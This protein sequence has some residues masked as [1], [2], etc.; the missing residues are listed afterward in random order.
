VRPKPVPSLY[1]SYTFAEHTNANVFLD[2]T[3]LVSQYSRICF[4]TVR[5][6]KKLRSFIVLFTITIA[7]IKNKKF[8]L[9]LTK[10][11]K[12]FSSF[13]SVVKLKIE[14]LTLS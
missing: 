12:A 2:K 10:R 8:K 1:F 5:K 4:H 14:V 6:E 7:T 9:M 13:G 3:P 11:A